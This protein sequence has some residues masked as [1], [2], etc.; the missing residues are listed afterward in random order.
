MPPTVASKEDFDR[1]ETK[2]DK[3]FLLLNG[4]GTPGI[5]TRL[6]VLENWREQRE[7]EIADERVQAQTQNSRV[8][9]ITKPFI[10]NAI[11][12]I[13]I[14]AVF[15]VVIHLPGVAPLLGLR[16]AP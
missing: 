1:L 3:V 2:I 13:I 16:V 15:L 14:I 8:W 12:T 11:S 4:N 6:V 7:K 9:E 10:V 5:F